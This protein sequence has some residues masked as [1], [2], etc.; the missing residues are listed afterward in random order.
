MIM[1]AYQHASQLPPIIKVPPQ[2]LS[3]APGSRRLVHHQEL[4]GKLRGGR[5]TGNRVQRVGAAVR[6]QVSATHN[7]GVLRRSEAMT[8]LPK[9]YSL[10]K[11]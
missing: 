6:L 10:Y 1:R 5:V 7:Q 2:V 4:G 8:I 9:Q 3:P 11:M